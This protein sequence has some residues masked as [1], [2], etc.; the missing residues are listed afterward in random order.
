M[1][2]LPQVL[3]WQ[4]RIDGHPALAMEW[5]DEVVI[6]VSVCAGQVVESIGAE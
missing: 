6:L 5:I 3:G 1:V 4:S 2:C